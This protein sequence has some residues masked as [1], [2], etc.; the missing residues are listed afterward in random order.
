MGFKIFLILYDFN[1]ENQF[2]TEE[3]I[4]AMW[5]DGYATSKPVIKDVDERN[6]EPRVSDRIVSSKGAAILRML[7]SIVLPDAFKTNMRVI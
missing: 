3:T 5:E 6:S 1:Q 2:L 7:E 4:K